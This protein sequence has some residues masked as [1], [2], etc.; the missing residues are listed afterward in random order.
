MD[1][2][3]ESNIQH[4]L[5]S[6]RTELASL[7]TTVTWAFWLAIAVLAFAPSEDVKGSLSKCTAMSVAARVDEPARKDQLLGYCMEGSGYDFNWGTDGCFMHDTERCY[8]K[9]GWWRSTKLTTYGW[10]HKAREW[11]GR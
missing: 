5:A 10:W 11:T 9:R 2:Q 4:A 1:Y 8:E 3:T 7:N 6:I